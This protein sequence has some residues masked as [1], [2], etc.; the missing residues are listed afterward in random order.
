MVR[1]FHSLA[2]LV[3][4]LHGCSVFSAAVGAEVRVSRTPS[5]GIQPQ[6]VSDGEALHLIYF[7]G[8]EAHG[9]VFYARSDQGGSTFSGP[10]RVNQTDDSAIAIGN[11]RGAHLALGKDGRAHVAWMGS[12]KASVSGP[13][14]ATPM[15]YTRLRDDRQGFEP[16][17]NVIQFAAG[18]DGGGSVAADREG[19][20]YVAW[21]AATP[22]GRT[23]KDRTVW[24]ARSCDEGAS[25][26]AET[27]AWSENVGACGC[28][29]MRAFAA[30]NSALYMLYRGAERPDQRDIYLLVSGDRGK[31][32][33]G[34][35][36]KPWKI[37][38]CP[39]SSASFSEGS[40]GVVAG[41]EGED[42][43][44]AALVPRNGDAPKILEP[45]GDGSK[46]RHPAVA[47]NQKGEILLA[48]VEGM[49]WKTPGQLKWALFDELGNGLDA[50]K[51]VQKVPTWGVVSVASTPDGNFVVLH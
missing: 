45:S 16:E 49:T 15:L 29:G 41:W 9:D 46:R 44:F 37:E 18:L 5:D 4:A 39:M 23:E 3:L 48:W 26:A 34:R 27:K 12:D 11:I 35:L 50:S 51:D 42:K 10:V 31:T 17:R 36:L 22:G 43:V 47:T 40:R 20:V 33:G 1:S 25:F 6:L 14:G 32:F 30:S 19:N 2:L 7:K 8:S 13:D 28:C 38:G 24:V 21:H